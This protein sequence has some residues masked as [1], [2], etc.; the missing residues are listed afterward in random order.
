MAKAT[1]G[2]VNGAGKLALPLGP[3]WQREMGRVVEETGGHSRKTDRYPIQSALS[4]QC[5]FG[6]WCPDNLALSDSAN[7]SSATPSTNHGADLYGK[8]PTLLVK[9]VSPKDEILSPAKTSLPAHAACFKTV[10][11]KGGVGA[12]SSA[13]GI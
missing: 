11:L 10:F 9:L 5:S 4:I 3:S 12:G 13:T 1:L 8:S 7:S 2:R 6:F